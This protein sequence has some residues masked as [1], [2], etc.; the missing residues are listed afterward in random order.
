MKSVREGSIRYVSTEI[1]RMAN[2]LG[3]DESVTKQALQIFVEVLNSEYSYSHL[4]D[5]SAACMYAAVRLR[6]EPVTIRDLG[7]VA[8]VDEKRLST[9]SKNVISETGL[10]VPPQRPEVLV[11]S[12][13]EDLGIPEEYHDNVRGLVETAS[14]HPELRNKANTTI[15]ASAI[16]AG[17]VLYDYEC[18]QKEAAKL[19]DTTDVTIRTNYGIILD[20]YEEE[21][22]RSKRRFGE[23]EEAVAT[24]TDDMELPDHVAEQVDARVKLAKHDLENG[25]SISG[26]VLAAVYVTLEQEDGYDELADVERLEGYAAAGAQTINKYVEYFQ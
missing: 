7:A 1:E 10:P 2:L 13:L 15:V 17:S 9:V 6:Q 21:L 18:S 11:E 19:V 3:I 12:A 16:Y 4:D 26:V 24:L 14:D 25:V 22:P 8:R 23:F 20:Q 5:L